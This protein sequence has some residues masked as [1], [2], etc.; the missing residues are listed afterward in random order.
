[1]EQ[2][3]E[4]MQER[5]DAWNKRNDPDYVKAKQKLSEYQQQELELLKFEQENNARHNKR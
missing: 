4:K 5:L 3:S 1:M 2:L